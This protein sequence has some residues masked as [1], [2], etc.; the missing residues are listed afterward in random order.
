MRLSHKIA[1]ATVSDQTNCH[2]EFVCADGSVCAVAD[3]N[4]PPT[5]ATK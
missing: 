1:A 5:S 2:A 4:A 3:F